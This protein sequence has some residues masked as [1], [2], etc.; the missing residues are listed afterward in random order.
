[1]KLLLVA[2]QNQ[3]SPQSRERS[4]RSDRRCESVK[5]PFRNCLSSQARRILRK[6]WSLGVY[7]A[8]KSFRSDSQASGLSNRSHHG[9]VQVNSVGAT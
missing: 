7:L 8:K 3:K 6:N 2:R 9:A 4:I 1:M 5:V